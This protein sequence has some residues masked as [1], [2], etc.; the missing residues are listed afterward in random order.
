MYIYMYIYEIYCIILIKRIYSSGQ[1]SYFCKHSL[2]LII[3]HM[4]FILYKL[5]II[6]IRIS[7]HFIVTFILSY[8]D[9]L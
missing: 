2:G 4:T 6:R 8:L 5:K 1:R 7:R 9:N 3:S